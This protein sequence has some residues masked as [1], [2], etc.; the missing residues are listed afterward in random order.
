[1]NLNSLQQKILTH[2]E[3]L[4]TGNQDWATASI[5]ERGKFTIGET[6]TGI[7]RSLRRGEPMIWNSWILKD[8]D[9]YRMFYLNLPATI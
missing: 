3:P 2:L 4:P 5:V 8:G 9:V 6:V 1:M 7:L